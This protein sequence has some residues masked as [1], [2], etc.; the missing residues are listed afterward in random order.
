METTKSRTGQ[1]MKGTKTNAEMAGDIYNSEW[2]KKEMEISFSQI[3]EKC[4]TVGDL[5]KLDQKVKE[6]NSEIKK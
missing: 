6:L 2:L 4:N 1:K 5:Q 3:S